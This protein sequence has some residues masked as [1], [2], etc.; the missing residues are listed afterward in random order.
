MISPCR[1]VL[2]DASR[3]RISMI[4]MNGL[5]VRFDIAGHLFEVRALNGLNHLKRTFMA[6]EVATTVNDLQWQWHL[7]SMDALRNQLAYVSRLRNE[8]IARKA[9]L[10]DSLGVS[11]KSPEGLK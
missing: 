1:N 8:A 11:L 9:A 3:L 2:K 4:P 10:L 7:G 6:R 5:P